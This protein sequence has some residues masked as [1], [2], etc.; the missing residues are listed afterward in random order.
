MEGIYI[1]SPEEASAIVRGLES[2]LMDVMSLGDNLY[3]VGSEKTIGKTYTVDL[4]E[5]TCTCPS[6][7]WR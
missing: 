3:E 6:Y 7:Q 5:G 4:L 1:K 2:R